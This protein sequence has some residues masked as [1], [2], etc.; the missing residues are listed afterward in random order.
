MTSVLG[1]AGG[2]VAAGGHIVA[3]Q[4]AAG[5]EQANA[6]AAEQDAEQ[7]RLAAAVDIESI[8]AAGEQARATMRAT[9]AAQ[10][11]RADEGSPLTLLMEG[12]RAERKVVLRRRYIGELEA[13][14]FL[15]E[16]AF[17]K[18]RASQIKTISAIN[19]V[20]SALS[21]A[22]VAYQGGQP[23]GSTGSAGSSSGGGGG[24]FD[25]A[26]MLL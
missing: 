3:G 24:S 9:A 2:V 6:K 25:G 4:Q 1:I 16:A 15:T 10:G 14:K 17:A 13:T 21:G 18:K 11:S 5:I 8:E 26:E 12:A 19:A 22:A 20:S 7:A 23:R